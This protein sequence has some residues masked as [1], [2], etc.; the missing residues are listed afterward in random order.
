[1]RARS[2]RPHR[3]H[4]GGCG[5]DARRRRSASTRDGRADRSADDHDDHDGSGGR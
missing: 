4:G 2:W 1:V 3:D 5:D